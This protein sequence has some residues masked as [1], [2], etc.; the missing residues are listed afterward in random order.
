MPNVRHHAKFRQNWS[1]GCGDI[2]HFFILKMA[3]VGLFGFSKF[4][5]YSS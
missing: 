2:A 4:Q 5:I 3:A 1:S